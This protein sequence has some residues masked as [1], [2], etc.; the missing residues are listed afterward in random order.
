MAT[1]QMQGHLRK[2]VEDGIQQK[3]R[4][5]NMMIDYKDQEYKSRE[6]IIDESSLE[7]KL[8]AEGIDPSKIN[9]VIERKQLDEQVL[10]RV[11]TILEE[12]QEKMDGLTLRMNAHLEELTEM[13]I[14]AGGFVTH[15][16][17]VDINATLDK[18]TMVI[19]F[20]PDGHVEIPIAARMN[21][22]K[23]SSQMIIKKIKKK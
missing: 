4:L 23:D 9:L 20:K 17:G 10:S 22:W 12:S 14:L 21:K 16:V 15:A 13:E 19:S 7:E 18:D 5:N 11:Q 2:Y 3:V 1:S 8:E 6:R